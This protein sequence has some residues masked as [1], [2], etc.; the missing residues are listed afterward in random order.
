MRRD[1]D[2]SI[3]F[4]PHSYRVSV[5]SHLSPDWLSLPYVVEVAVGYA[6]DGR[7]LT[8]LLLRVANQSDLI[9]TLNELHGVGLPLLSVHLLPEA[10]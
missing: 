4:S 10:A 1:E 7:P 5:E 8:T 6:E 3:S 9:A 2:T